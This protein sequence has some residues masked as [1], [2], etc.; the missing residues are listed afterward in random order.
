M[1]SLILYLAYYA[2]AVL[3]GFLLR[4]RFDAYIYRLPHM[5]RRLVVYSTDV[6]TA[7]EKGAN[8]VPPPPLTVDSDAV[9]PLLEGTPLSRFVRPTEADRRIAEANAD[10]ASAADPPSAERRALDPDAASGVAEAP[11]GGALSGVPPEKESP[12]HPS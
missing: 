6:V 10:E 1:R 2:L 9:T 4:T 5:Q 8:A 7:V 12:V 11:S 3:L